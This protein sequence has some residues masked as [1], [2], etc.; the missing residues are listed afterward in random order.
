[1][2]A[3]YSRYAAGV[4]VEQVKGASYLRPSSTVV[5]EIVRAQCHF[6]MQ[7]LQL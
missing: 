2:E 1:M 5:I 7:Y 3:E 6:S 4:V